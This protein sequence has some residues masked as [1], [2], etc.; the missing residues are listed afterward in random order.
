MLHF[1]LR[2]EKH[3]ST[4]TLSLTVRDTQKTHMI[5]L[6]YLSFGY[7]GLG[8]LE[9]V[10]LNICNPALEQRDL[11]EWSCVGQHPLLKCFYNLEHEG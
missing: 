10:S 4:L 9:P 11:Q 2:K 7:K 3:Y 8:L 6:G 5:L 1:P